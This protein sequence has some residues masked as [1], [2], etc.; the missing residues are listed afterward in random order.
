VCAKG[1]DPSKR[2]CIPIS[3]K[4]FKVVLHSGG[5]LLEAATLSAVVRT[6]Y[7]HRLPVGVHAEGPGQARR[8]FEAGADILVHVPWPESLPEELLM[9]MAA[10]MTW[11]S[12][13]AL[14]RGADLDRALDNARRFLRLG[15]RLEYG[16][17]IGNGRTPPGPW[18]EEIN[19][20][21]KTGL[22]GDA[23]LRSLT[24]PAD[25][26]L[27]L[28]RAVYVPLPLP[29]EAAEIA[30]WINQAQRLAGALQEVASA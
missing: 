13:F 23:L 11:I 19:A 7:R 1:S 20:L 25:D 18:T 26:G 28:D 21:G 24:G 10:S 3:G 16:T 15:V 2:E 4:R 29:A 27:L 8:A 9:S 12:T 6:A 14:H 22:A 17:E 30:V 5:P